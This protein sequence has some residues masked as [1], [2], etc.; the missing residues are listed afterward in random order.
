VGTSSGALVG[1][2]W[3]AG[4]PAAQ[5]V[6]ELASR[7]PLSLMAPNPRFWQGLFHLGPLRA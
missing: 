7:R 3:V 6:E 4:M 2:L 1:A 5:L